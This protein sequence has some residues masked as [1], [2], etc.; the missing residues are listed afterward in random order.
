VLE[1]GAGSGYQAAILGE[2]A[3]EVYGVELIPQLADRAA[4]TLA[5]LGYSNVHIRQGD[6]YLGWPA[7]APFDAIIVS[8]G[9]SEIP[10]PLI[11]QLRPGGKMIIPVGDVAL[12]QTLQ[13]ITKEA[14]GTVTTRRQ[15][16]V[17]FVPL[18][19]AEDVF[20]N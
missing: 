11:E 16:P 15:L 10:E 4:R 5:R 13:L 1:V 9:A 6:G 12:N 18:R 20:Q 2:L 19:R 17:R 8:C 7:M 14:D 3:A